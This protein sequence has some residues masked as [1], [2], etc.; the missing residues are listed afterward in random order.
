MTDQGAPL[1]RTIVVVPTIRETCIRDFLAAWRSEFQSDRV[2]VFVVE[3]NPERTFDLGAGVEG[4]DVTHFCWQDIERDLGERAWIVP[5]RTDC[6]RSYGYWKAFQEQPEM[7]VTLDDDCYPQ[8]PGFL[9]QHWQRLEQGGRENAWT[10]SGIGTKPRGIP[11]YRQQRQRPCIINHGMWTNV[12]DFDAPTQL[13]QARGATGFTFDDRT[14]PV[15]Q[16]FPM[17]GMNLAFRPEAVP[18]L[19][20]LLMGKGYEYDRFGDIWA[21]VFVKK[22]ADHL[23]WAINSGSPA[24][25]H[26]RASN[27]WANLR[28]E[29]PGLEVNE[30]LWAAVDAAVLEETTFAGCYRELAETLAAVDAGDRGYFAKLAEAMTTWAALFA[31]SDD[32]A[33]LDAAIAVA[34]DAESRAAEPQ[35]AP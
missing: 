33:V 18:A 7:I 24:I 34:A 20:F 25:E 27:V 11:Y 4:I 31:D 29:T 6:V 3:D 15:G 26:Q 28:K 35:P 23:G 1:P 10:S 5:R 16:F 9:Q 30:H 12:P 22:I 13:L 32:G 21:G 19:Y 17:C 8:G 14:I 2:R